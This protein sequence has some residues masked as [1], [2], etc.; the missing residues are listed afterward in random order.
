MLV[1]RRN[2]TSVMVNLARHG[3]FIFKKIKLDS[4]NLMKFFI[5]LH[6]SYKPDFYHL[7]FSQFSYILQERLMQPYCLTLK[8][9]II[10]SFIYDQTDALGMTRSVD[11]P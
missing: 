11:L 1:V 6:H 3:C 2:E 7:A 9:N 10:S 5:R 8:E 4:A